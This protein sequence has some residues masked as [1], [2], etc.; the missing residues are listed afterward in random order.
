MH[1]CSGSWPSSTICSA[2]DWRSWALALY[3]D[4][5]VGLSPQDAWRWQGVFLPG[6]RMGAPPSRTNPEGQ[7]WGY[8]VLDPAKLGRSIR[9][10]RRSSS[11]GALARVLEECDG[12]RIDHPHGWVDPWVYAAEDPD[13]LHAVQNGGR[14]F[15]S[16]NSAEHPALAPWRSLALTSSTARSSRTPTAGC[17]DL[18]DEQVAKYAILIDTIVA[19]QARRNRPAGDIACEVLSTMPYPV[20]RVMQRHGIGRFRV[21]QKLNL[22][23]ES[24]VYR[25]EH[26]EPADWVM[27][28]T[29]DTPTVWE[30]AR[31][32]SESG[33]AEAWGKYIAKRLA[34]PRRGICGPA[35]RGFARQSREWAVHRHARQPGPACECV[36]SRPFGHDRAVQCTRERER[37]ELEPADSG[38]LRRA[39][40]RTLPAGRGAECGPLPATGEGGSRELEAPATLAVHSRLILAGGD[41][42]R[43]GRRQ[44][45]QP[46]PHLLFGQ[47][48]LRQANVRAVV[49][50]FALEQAAVE[51]GQFAVGQEN[52]A[53]GQTA[54]SCALR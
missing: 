26:A 39:V 11:S 18:D 10:A 5:Q 44:F 42:G 36:L 31:K 50:G 21:T 24:D 19:E 40:G 48:L 49:P 8:Y 17:A 28:G 45:R 38:R 33:A 7:P 27:L 16:P 30:L 29:H 54:R 32:W 6:Y 2:S 23:N 14:Q 43:L 25:L 12:V 15:S 20:A 47:K 51:I 52:R 37:H 35:F 53:R 1:S 3:A 46:R 22:T 34:G 4:L 13:P 41:D 9:R